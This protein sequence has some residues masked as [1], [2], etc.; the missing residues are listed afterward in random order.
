MKMG[1]PLR[2]NNKRISE[3]N[4]Y[5]SYYKESW[6][7]ISREDILIQKWEHNENDLLWNGTVECGLNSRGSY[8]NYDLSSN[9]ITMK[10]NF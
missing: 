5:Q 10:R 9:Q 8:L 3:M 2:N 1:H 7:R 4:A 6:G